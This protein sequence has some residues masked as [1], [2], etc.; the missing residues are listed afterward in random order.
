MELNSLEQLFAAAGA[1]LA[2]CQRDILW[3]RTLAALPGPA[4]RTGIGIRRLPV[5]QDGRPSKLC[6]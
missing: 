3:S 4:Y 1:F 5:S 6:S 2:T